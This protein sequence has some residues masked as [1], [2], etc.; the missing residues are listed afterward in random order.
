M[1][2]KNFGKEVKTMP[3]QKDEQ[4][5]KPRS[6]FLSFETGDMGNSLILLSHL[7]QLDTHYLKDK[8][9]FVDCR[10]GDCMYCAADY[11]ISTEY[12]YYVDLNGQ[13]GYL[14]IKSSVF[15]DVKKIAKAQGKDAR[16]I[17]WTVIKT[18]S[19]LDTKYTTTKDDN[20]TAEDYERV[21]GGLDECDEKL[22]NLMQKHETILS[23]NYTAHLKDIK[24]QTPPKRAVKKED[25]LEVDPNDVPD[26]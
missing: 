17:S 12:N 10:G 5:V 14:N 22:E 8:N 6:Q 4:Q 2:I 3:L 13:K 9:V 20:L 19:G 1:R 21:T 18:G 11:T 25:E 7:Y 23:D 26:F 24:G 16:Q 15:F